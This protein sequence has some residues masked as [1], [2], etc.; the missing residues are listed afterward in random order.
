L[1]ETTNLC[2]VA[3]LTRPVR[4]FRWVDDGAAAGFRGVVGA[5]AALV[6]GFPHVWY[7]HI[8]RGLGATW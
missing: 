2:S 4:L 7:L 5:T 3:E 1:I 6:V 8:T